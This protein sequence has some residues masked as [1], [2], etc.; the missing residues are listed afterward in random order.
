M[1][2]A[3]GVVPSFVLAPLPRYLVLSGERPSGKQ[4]QPSECPKQIL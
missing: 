4:M 1:H 3:D 2:G